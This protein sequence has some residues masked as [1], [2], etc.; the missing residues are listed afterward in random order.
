MPKTVYKTKM[1]THARRVAAI[2]KAA[3]GCWWVEQYLMD[4]F[5]VTTGW[6]NHDKR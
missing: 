3:N 2:K 4:S 6:K 5:G 1:P